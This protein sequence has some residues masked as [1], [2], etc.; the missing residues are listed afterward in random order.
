MLKDNIKD[1][2]E[3]VK[4]GKMVIILDDESRENEGDLVCAADLITPEIVNFM[5]SKGKGLICLPMS[6]NLCSKYDLQMMTNNNKAANRTAFTVSIEAAE[7]ITTGI[8]AADRAHTIKTAVDNKSVASDIVQPGHIFPLKAMDGGVLSRAGHTEAACDLAKLAGLQSAG[9]I[10]EIMNEDGTMAR[11]DDLI[12]FGKEHEIKVGTIADLI[13]YRLSSDSTVESVH[14]RNITNEFGNF[15]LI[16]WRDT[17]NDEYH[18][19]LSKGDLSKVKSPLVRVQTQSILQD[20]LGIE[21]LGKNW[22]IRKSIERI[23]KEEAGLFVLINHRD[24]KSYWLNILEE[25]EV[26]PKTNRRVIGVGSQIL[27]ALNLK[28]ITVLGTPTKYNAVS[29]FNIEITGFINE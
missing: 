6:A 13:D 10:C 14:N 19:S 1:I 12:K 3:D 22:S 15:N 2:I 4:N 5:A 7:G 8:S 29:G 9:V 25:K 20:T 18:Y 23:S 24:A 26:E 17:I 27:R 28:E 16:V 21:E 11:R